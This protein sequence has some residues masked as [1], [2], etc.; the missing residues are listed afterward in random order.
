MSLR[1]RWQTL[2]RD[3]RNS[4]IAFGSVTTFFGV[5]MLAGWL[6]RDVQLPRITPL[7][8]IGF[9]AL[10]LL[11]QGILWWRRRMRARRQQ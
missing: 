8:L 4:L 3:A 5:A 9:L 7:M 1:S 2:S 6:L 10:Q 11:L